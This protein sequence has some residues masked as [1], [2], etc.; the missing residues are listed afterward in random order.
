MPD[1]GAFGV[2]GD[3]HLRV[4]RPQSG[5]GGDG[6]AAPAAVVRRAG[7][8]HRRRQARLRRARHHRGAGLRRAGDRSSRPSPAIDYIA[9]RCFLQPLSNVSP[10]SMDRVVE[11]SRGRQAGGA[12]QCQRDAQQS[13]SPLRG[14]QFL[15]HLHLP[16]NELRNFIESD[17]IFVWFA[18]GRSIHLRVAPLQERPAHLHQAILRHLAL[19]TAPAGTL[20]QFSKLLC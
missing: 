3:D 2:G 13:R 18:D 11:A 8:V 6:I 9:R 15:N 17:E 1:R 19:S 16:M 4:R 5:G 20:A 10:I 7:G 12:R 14:L